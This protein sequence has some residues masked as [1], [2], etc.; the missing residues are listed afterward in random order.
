MLTNPYGLRANPY[1]K[2]ARKINPHILC[3]TGQPDSHFADQ[4]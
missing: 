1:V 2:W 4:V 3:E